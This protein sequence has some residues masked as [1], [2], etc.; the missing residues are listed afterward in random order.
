MK[1]CI[2]L[3]F[4]FVVVPASYAQQ[5]DSVAD[6]PRFEFKTGNIHDFGNVQT[7]TQVS[8]D[9]EFTNV[10]NKPLVITGGMASCGCTTPTFP[11]EP[12]LPGKKSKITVK[13]NAGGPDPFSKTV[14]IYSNAVT[15]APGIYDIHII[16]TV[17]DTTKK[18]KQ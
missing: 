7:G 12:I 16:G 15:G 10:G 17:V 13:F 9:F 5:Q 8:Y 18:P 1:S 6:G 14:F 3:L 11:K 2:L 4:F